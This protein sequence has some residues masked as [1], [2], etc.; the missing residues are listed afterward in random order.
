[1]TTWFWLLWS[2]FIWLFPQH[3]HTQTQVVS[4]QAMANDL[5]FVCVSVCVRVWL[6]CNTPGRS[7]RFEVQA[8][9]TDS[10]CVCQMCVIKEFIVLHSFYPPALSSLSPAFSLS[11]SFS[12]YFLFLQSVT[13]M[14]QCHT[15]R[16][17]PSLPLTHT[18]DRLTFFNV[19]QWRCIKKIRPASSI[20]VNYILKLREHQPVGS[21]PPYLHTKCQVQAPADQYQGL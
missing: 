12:V 3:L 21:R 16:S 6:M 13:S 8:E 1:M 10:I 18:K 17:G 4:D 14:S 9:L 7:G 15:W 19:M 20:M 11:L 5:L 2:H